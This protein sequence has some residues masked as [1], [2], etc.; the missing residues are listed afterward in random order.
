MQD[1]KNVLHLAKTS[2][3]G[4]P[5][6]IVEALNKYTNYNARLATYLPITLSDGQY[7]FKEDITWQNP[8]QRSEILELVKNAD[9][10]HMHHYMNTDLSNPFMIDLNKVTKPNC[11]F[12]RHFHSSHD[13]I[14]KTEIRFEDNYQ[15]DKLPKVVIPHYPERTFLN[16]DIVPN[17]IPI[18][19]SL[20]TP[21]ETNNTKLK[22]VF[23]AS[24]KASRKSDRW[25][26]K[27]YPEVSDLLRQLS[28]KY[29][30][31]YIEINNITFAEA[32]K[33]KQQADIVIGDVVTGSYHLT[34]LEALSQGKPTI[35]YLDGRSVMT[36][37]NT[38]KTQDIPFINANIDSLE[39]VIS[40]LISDRELLKQIG[41]FSRA[42]IEKYY[43]DSILINKFVE[44]Y[45]NILQDKDITRTNT[46]EFYNVKEFLY[47]T[48]Y[49]YDWKRITNI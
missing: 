15:K 10:I 30:F 35:T 38:F 11:K 26:T 4:A 18:N 37:M 22:I 25:A 40:D 8:N 46:K 3:A 1:K 13:Y 47:N 12:L 44:I 16:L 17:I 33:I 45:D 28:L 34:E 2:L 21:Y 6:R 14:S 32:M 43:D 24:N 27:G 39:Q 9:I 48:V 19:E 49:D 31:E 7:M 42:W 29:N 41:K 20:Y 5:I 36:F 23:S